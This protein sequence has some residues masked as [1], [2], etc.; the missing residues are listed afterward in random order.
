MHDP[1]YR[2]LV[3]QWGDSLADAASYLP[4]SPWELFRPV[5]RNGGTTPN[6]ALIWDEQHREWYRIDG[7]VAVEAIFRDAYM[8]LQSRPTPGKLKYLADNIGQVRAQ[9]AAAD[10]LATYLRDAGRDAGTPRNQAFTHRAEPEEI[11]AGLRDLPTFRAKFVYDAAYRAVVLETLDRLRQDLV[12]Q[13]AT[14]E[15]DVRELDTLLGRHG[16]TLDSQWAQGPLPEN[17]DVRVIAWFSDNPKARF[18]STWRFERE[19]VTIDAHNGDVRNNGPAQGIRTGNVVRSERSLPR[20]NCIASDERVFAKD[21]KLT[22]S[23]VYVCT[24]QDGTTR[25]NNVSGAGTWQVV[26]PSTRLP[27]KSTR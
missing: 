23:S 15:A 11:Q 6:V 8:S 4:S 16:I 9:E 17:G 20:R 24:L 14:A 25:I 27:D 1:R 10:A 13:G 18:A 19:K 21:G 7:N 22:F 26:S 3:A 12:T 5:A 2:Q